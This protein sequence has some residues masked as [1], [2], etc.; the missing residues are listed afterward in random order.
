[1]HNRGPGGEP[2][3]PVEQ[4]AGTWRL[5]GPRLERGCPWR[6]AP[7]PTLLPTKRPVPTKLPFTHA[8]GIP[9]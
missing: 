8:Y 5:R 7:P 1:M 2:A 6:T 3:E 9:C 4:P